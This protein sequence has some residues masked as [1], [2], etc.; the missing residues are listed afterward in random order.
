VYILTHQNE[1]LA[2]KDSISDFRKQ[3][4]A[5]MCRLQFHRAEIEKKHRMKLTIYESDALPL[6]QA[7]FELSQLRAQYYKK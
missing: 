2:Y 1:P 3:E 7:M 4:A 5:I 6:K